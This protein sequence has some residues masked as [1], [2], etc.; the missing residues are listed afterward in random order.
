YAD[1]LKTGLLTT[2]VQAR[3]VLG[4]MR[5]LEAAGIPPSDVRVIARDGDGAATDAIGGI[6]GPAILQRARQV[7]RELYNIAAALVPPA[8]AVIESSSIGAY[9][10][11]DVI[12]QLQVKLKT[13]AERA[14]TR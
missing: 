14:G 6:Q 7:E 1:E 10:P 13:D 12:E 2:L 9:R 4:W 11:F 3:A 8:V 5:N